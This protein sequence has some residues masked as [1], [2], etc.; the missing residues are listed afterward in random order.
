MRATV[1]VPTFNEASKVAELVGRL[2]VALAGQ[3]AEALFVDDSTDDTP[4][5]VNEVAAASVLPV[6]PFHRTGEQRTGGLAGAVS[7]GIREAHSD[8]IVVMDG[9]LQHPPEL[10]AELISVREIHD[11]DVVVASRYRGQSGAEGLSSSWR[12]GVSP[13]STLL[14]RAMFPRRVGR[15]CSDPM[16]GFFCLNRRS[17][18][19]KASWRQGA[20]FLAQLAGLRLHWPQTRS[21]AIPLHKPVREGGWPARP[22]RRARSWQARCPST[23][24]SRS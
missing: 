3:G 18:D 17:I 21:T 9:D 1:V 10:V 7:T 4:V 8:V 16:T 14:A 20:A 19:S 12:H 6:R 2:S 23:T 11:G 24:H 5:R 15:T 13:G 22:R